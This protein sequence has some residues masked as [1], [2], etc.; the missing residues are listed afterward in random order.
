MTTTPARIL[1]AHADALPNARRYRSAKERETE[2]HILQAAKPVLANNGRAT[3][4]FSGLA[5][6]IRIPAGTLRRHFPD[7]DALLSE[8]LL[9][10]LR[11]IAD[12][13]GRIPHNTPNSQAARRAAYL[14]ATRSPYGGPTEGHILLLRD[15]HVLPPDLAEP[16]EKIRQSIGDLLAYPNGPAALALLDTPGT[17]PATIETMFDALAPTPPPSEDPAPTLLPA[18]PRPPKKNLLTGTSLVD[19]API[20]FPATLAPPPPGTLHTH[21]APAPHPIHRIRQVPTPAAWQSG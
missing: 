17:T 1:R 14:A 9:R 20:P 8:L 18:A 4:S 2:D 11:A 15:R 10:H 7:L 6:A 21:K 13:L 16:L 3:T 19:S 5:F 12:E